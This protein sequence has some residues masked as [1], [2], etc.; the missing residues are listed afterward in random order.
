MQ[1]KAGITVALTM[2]GKNGDLVAVTLTSRAVALKAQSKR[3]LIGQIRK[4]AQRSPKHKTRNASALLALSAQHWGN[5]T[6][7]RCFCSTAVCCL[8]VVCF[9]YTKTASHTKDRKA[10]DKQ[11]RCRFTAGQSRDTVQERK[12]WTWPLIRRYWGRTKKSEV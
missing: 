2:L 5:Y 12:V 10:G 6:T 4:S 11:F 3:M 7:A 1:G 8:G 9:Y